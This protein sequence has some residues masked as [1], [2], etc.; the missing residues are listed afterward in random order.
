MFDISLKHEFYKL[1]GD[2]KITSFEDTIELYS[3][4]NSTAAFQIVVA[5]DENVA[6]NLGQSDW[7]SHNSD[8]TVLRFEYE[9][10]FT[11]E[12][13]ILGFITDDDGK[14]KADIL[15]K[16]DAVDFIGT[17]GGA[18]C[19]IKIPK[20]AINGDYEGKIKIY[21]KKMFSPETL[22]KTLNVKL[23][24]SKYTL[25]DVI[26]RDLHLDLWQ[27]LSNIARHHDVSLWSDEHFAVLE[28][29]VA[30]LADLGQKAVTLVVSEIPWSGQSC[31]EQKQF[32]SNLFEYS[33]V[34]TKKEGENFYFDYSTMQRYIDLCKKYGIV[35]ELSI[36]GLANVWK[37]P[38][39]GYDAVAADYPD[40]VRIRYYDGNDGTYK[41]MTEAKDIDLF[42]KS[43]EA[44][45]LST[46]QMEA[47]RLCADEPADVEAYKK[48]IDHLLEIA[49]SFKL[50]AAINHAEFIGEFK[51]EIFDFVPYIGCLAKEY[52]RVQDYKKIMTDKRFLWYVCC[53]PDYPNTF[54]KSP[55][56]ESAFIGILTSYMELHGFLRWNYTVY[57][58][59]P[60]ND[61][62]Y[63][64]FPAGDI[65]FVY[66]ANNGGAL[67]SLRYKALKRGFDYYEML[68]ALKRAGETDLVEKCYDIVVKEKNIRNYFNDNFCPSVM[69]CDDNGMYEFVKIL[70]T[71]LNKIAK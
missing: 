22:I 27:H 51:N 68:E 40:A 23:Y 67:L 56:R 9:G 47:V 21:A 62:R 35:D 39:H 36:Y 15:L 63:G 14:S 18:Y 46:D 30:T 24:V 28:K 61:L 20:N 5:N 6:I 13:N 66:P 48:S 31:F 26:E 71:S 11:C 1:I 45:F 12:M 4:P 29:Y 54:I 41:Y 70:V 43:L 16:N 25:S 8:V 69:M 19:E 10:M 3:T 55:L 50:K 37:R 49:P 52:D 2:D 58:K 7:F 32:D 57:N 64:T 65:N 53:G 33:I 17:N 42:V 38:E 59:D 60:R 44:Y 34:K